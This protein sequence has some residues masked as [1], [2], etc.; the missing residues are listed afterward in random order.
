MSLETY[1]LAKIIIVGVALAFAI[2]V[3]IWAIFNI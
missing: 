2:G 3:G 1:L